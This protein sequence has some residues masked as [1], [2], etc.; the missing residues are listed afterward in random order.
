MLFE[1]KEHQPN[2]ITMKSATTSKWNLHYLL[3]SFAILI[4]L[5]ACNQQGNTERQQK[6]D[7]LKAYVEERRDS[8]DNY[9]DRTWDDMNAEFEQRRRKL[10]N[11]TADMNEEMRNAYYKS[12]EDWNNMKNN[13]QT[14]WTE[15]ARVKK[16]DELRSTLVINGVR[17]DYTDLPASRLIEQYEHFV[18]TVNMHKDEYTADEWQVINVNYKAL[19]GRK[20]ELESQINAPDGAK[21][22]KLQLQYTG[23]KAVNRPVAENP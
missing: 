14:R 5:A 16:E 6:L 20:R 9:L 21:I 2:Q 18:S 3:G 10:E 7:D 12:V 1:I 22:T 19:N 11:D 8:M 15:H 17:P 4:I 23:I 13:F